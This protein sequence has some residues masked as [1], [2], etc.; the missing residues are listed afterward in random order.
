MNHIN[1]IVTVIIRSVEERTEQLCH[2]LILSQGIEPTNV[3][4]VREAPF[5]SA[6]R[7]SFKIGIERGSVWTLCVD[8]DLLLRPD[9][10]RR[11]LQLADNLEE[12][13]FEIQGYILD[14]FFGGPRMGGIHLYRSNLLSKA[15]SSMPEE[16]CDIRP[17]C[18]TLQIMQSK[19]Y[20]W[21]SVPYIVGLHDF[22]QYYRDIFRKCFVQ[23]H[24]HEYLA[25]LFLSIWRNGIRDDMDYWVGLQGFAGGIAHH[26]DVHIDIRQEF[27]Q[28]GFE[29]LQ[30]GE[31]EPLR[32]GQVTPDSVENIIKTWIEP[33]LYQIKFPTKMG[34]IPQPSMKD[35]LSR[36][37][38]QLGPIRIIPYSFGWLLNR[39]GDR[40]KK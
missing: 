40:L 19:G 4:I 39:I 14:K 16:D 24:K 5:S 21:I 7:R 26:A 1:K 29:E 10:I 37:F 8:A 28:K 13:V 9:S 33:E 31:K 32:P 3:S 27:L 35:N 12:S 34:L 17:E 6:L 30:I 25:D 11:M 36:Q 15:L 38:K 20:R 23:A 18:Q 2:E 22:E